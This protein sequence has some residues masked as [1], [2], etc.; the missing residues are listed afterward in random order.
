MGLSGGCGCRGGLGGRDATGFWGIKEQ[1]IHE[2]SPTLLFSLVLR[3]LVISPVG[4]SGRLGW[5]REGVCRRSDVRQF[6]QL[7]F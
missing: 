1:R 2:M 7:L 4:W 5:R 3:M 6:E